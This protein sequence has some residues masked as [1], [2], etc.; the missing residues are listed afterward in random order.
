MLGQR[1]GI[2]TVKA[3]LGTPLIYGTRQLDRDKRGGTAVSRCGQ[4]SHELVPSSN[5]PELKP[6]FLTANVL[7][8]RALCSWT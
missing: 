7:W 2:K 5:T 6:N 1:I 8:P 3:N 4:Q